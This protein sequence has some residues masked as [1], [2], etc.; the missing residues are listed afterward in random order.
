M[1]Y[2]PGMPMDSPEKII[3]QAPQEVVE[4]AEQLETSLGLQSSLSLGLSISEINRIGPFAERYEIICEIGAGG[5]GVVYKAK[6]R[7][8]GKTCAVKMLRPMHF[9]DGAPP[10]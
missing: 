4:M 9:S 10:I 7:L 8:L 3:A 1:L 5:M 2:V 6:Q